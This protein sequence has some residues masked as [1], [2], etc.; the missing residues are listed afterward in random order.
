MP[1]VGIVLRSFYLFLFV[2]SNRQM[3]LYGRYI[4]LLF[5]NQRK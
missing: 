4:N 1:R 2:Q 5:L 3:T